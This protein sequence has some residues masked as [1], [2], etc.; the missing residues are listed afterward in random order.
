MK[1]RCFNKDAHNYK[2]YGGRG[3]TVCKR[4]LKFENFYNDMGERPKD[5]T[6]DREDN[7][8][9]YKPSNCKWST[10]KEQANNKRP[11]V[12]KKEVGR[13]PSE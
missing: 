13:G 1:N 4:W 8:G 12:V 7:E 10:L 3:I 6:I 2:Y 9:G 5:K 11:I